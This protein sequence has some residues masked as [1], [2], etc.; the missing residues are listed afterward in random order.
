MPPKLRIMERNNSSS[1]AN[2]SEVM[3]VVILQTQQIH[4]FVGE[5]QTEDQHPVIREVQQ[6]LQVLTIS[7]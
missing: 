6:V 7:H 2:L 1:F 5:R 3:L 4:P